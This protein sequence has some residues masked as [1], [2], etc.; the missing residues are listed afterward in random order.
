[1]SVINWRVLPGT[2]WAVGGFFGSGKTDLLATAA[3]LQRPIRGQV[4]LFGQETFTLHE[5]A[6]VQHRRRIGLVFPNGGRLFNRLTIAENVA[7]PLRYHQNLVEAEAESAVRDVLEM[8]DLIPFAHH[9]P[10]T[11]NNSWEQRA[12]IARALILKPE[13]LLLDKPLLAL[14]L[15][16]QR[17]MLDFISEMSQGSTFLG[18]RPLTIVVTSESLE[19]WKN[20]AKQFALLRNKEWREIAGRA[21]LDASGELLQEV[22]A[23]E[24]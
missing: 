10:S 23:D 16:H 22:W 24:S 9:V 17:W 12:A 20:V 19:P 18:D 21:E 6:V 11:L 3:G 1:M 8:T 14:D 13:V 5:E 2:F 7:L 4:K 15:R